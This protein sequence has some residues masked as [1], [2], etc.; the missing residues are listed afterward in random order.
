MRKFKGLRALLWIVGFRF[1]KAPLLTSDADISLAIINSLKENPS[2]WVELTPWDE[3]AGCLA[4]D[5]LS[6]TK[7]LDRITVNI[8]D[9]V[10]IGDVDTEVTMAYVVLGI[11]SSFYINQEVKQLLHTRYMHNRTRFDYLFKT[12]LNQH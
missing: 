10:Y 12:I 1:K 9:Y 6:V 11:A 5:R 7:N 4:C 3:S 8:K 2:S